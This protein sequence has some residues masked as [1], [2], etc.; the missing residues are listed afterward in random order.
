MSYISEEQKYI[1][2]ISELYINETDILK[3][4]KLSAPNNSSHMQLTAL[5]GKILQT[6]VKIKQPS[7]ILEI[8]TLVGYSSAWISGALNHETN[9]FITIEKETKHYQIA[10]ENFQ[11]YGLNN[12]IQTHLIKDDPIKDIFSICEKNGP[13][14]FIFIDGA[15][16]EYDKYVDI[17]EKFTKKGSIIAIDNTLLPIKSTQSRSSTKKHIHTFNL[18]LSKNKNFDSIIIPTTSGLTIAIKQ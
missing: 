3:N 8:G 15:K 1:E 16:K 4:I 6:I 10:K 5:E 14:D 2:Y 9:K 13:F 12:I 18:K 11:K 17:A 7:T